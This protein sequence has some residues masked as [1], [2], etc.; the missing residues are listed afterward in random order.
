MRSAF[1]HDIPVDRMRPRDGIQSF[2][3]L[4]GGHF[5][6]RACGRP[7]ARHRSAATAPM[8]ADDFMASLAAG[9]NRPARFSTI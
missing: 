5:H 2:E 4:V 1:A 6:V 8:M 3:E 9:R 7:A